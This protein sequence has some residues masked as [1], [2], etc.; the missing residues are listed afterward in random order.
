MGACE[1]SAIHLVHATVGVLSDQTP[2]RTNR[3]STS[4]CRAIWW[5]GTAAISRSEL[6]RVPRGL[7][8]ETI[9][10]VMVAEKG[11]R[12]TSGRRSRSPLIHTPLAPA[13]QGVTKASVVIVA[14][15][16]LFHMGRAMCQVGD[17]VGEVKEGGADIARFAQA[18]DLWFASQGL[19]DGREQAFYT[20]HDEAHVAKVAD[21]SALAF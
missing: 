7:V 5:R 8:L 3:R 15:H 4:C 17:H 21:D 14:W 20:G 6:V 12:H 19:V 1:R 16:K 13:A 9:W 10:L 18:N 11:T 2:A